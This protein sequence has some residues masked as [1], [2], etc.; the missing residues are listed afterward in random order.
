MDQLRAADV[1]AADVTAAD[2]ARELG[3]LLQLVDQAVAGITDE[4]VQQRLDELT[5]QLPRLA[6]AERASWVAQARDGGSW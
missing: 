5:A 6:P 4:Q 2:V 3:E 1:T